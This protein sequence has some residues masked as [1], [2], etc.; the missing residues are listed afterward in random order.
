MVD[1]AD[2]DSG[3]VQASDGVTVTNVDPTL[4]VSALDILE[5]GTTTLSGTITDIGRLDIHDVTIDWDD[6]NDTTGAHFDLDAIFTINAGTGVTTAVLG[7][8]G[9]TSFN[10]TSEDSVLTITGVNSTTGEITFTVDHQY[11]DDGV[12]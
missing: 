3:M 12:A 4:S 11:L 6:D 8:L 7:E 10:S 2:D 5:N 9:F 1:V